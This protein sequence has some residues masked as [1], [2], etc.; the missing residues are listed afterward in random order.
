MSEAPAAPF[1]AWEREIAFRYLRARRSEGG[2]ALISIIS[3][4][5]IM[6]AVAVLIIVM[7]VMNGFRADLSNMILG[8]NGHDYVVTGPLSDSQMDATLARIRAAPH[9]VQAYP[10]IESQTLAQSQTGAAGAVVRGVRLADLEATP[11]IAH[12]IKAGSLAGFGQGE[13]GGDMVLMGSRLAESLDL[14]PGDPVTLLSPAS[15]ATAMG[16]MPIQK[17]YV[18]AGLF[19]VGMSEYDQAFIYM[20]LKQAQL[21]FGRDASADYIE[22]KLDNP[23]LAPKLKPALAAAAGP[24][25]VV[26]DWTQKNQAYFGALAVEHNVMF[27]ILAL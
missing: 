18:V 1:S 25:A 20:P 21:F 7:S 22:V 6:L 9:V 10:V 19:Q 4:L 26:S 3:F 14:S 12:N 8:F 24:G 2:V 16:V 11:L 17:T 5:G 27:L 13:D 15:T 23:D